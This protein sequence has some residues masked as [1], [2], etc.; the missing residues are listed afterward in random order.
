LLSPLLEGPNGLPVAIVMG[1][2]LLLLAASAWNLARLVAPAALPLMEA[3]S[4]AA[5]VRRLAAQ[6]GAGACAALGPVAI[7]V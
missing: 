7:G 5:A 4:L 3:T 2:L 1:S 6:H